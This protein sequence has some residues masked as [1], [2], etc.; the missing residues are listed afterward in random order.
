MK[1]KKNAVSILSMKR[2]LLLIFISS[3]LLLT[4]GCSLSCISGHQWQDATCTSPKKCLKCGKTDGAALSHI[5]SE[6]TCT[7]P[8]KC[9]LCGKEQ[10]K[11]LG[12]EI[13]NAEILKS[14]TCAENGEMKGRCKICGETV[15]QDIEPTGDHSVVWENEVFPCK[16]GTR[17]GKCSVCG[18]E[19]NEEVKKTEDHQGEWYITDYNISFNANSGENINVQQEL[20]CKVCGEK[21]QDEVSMSKEEYLN[22]TSGLI[23]LNNKRFHGE[24]YV[25]YQLKNTLIKE[26]RE[27]SYVNVKATLVDKNGNAIAS[28]EDSIYHFPKGEIH[29]GTICIKYSGEINDIKLEVSKVLMMN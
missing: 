26:V 29:E 25:D 24:Y 28:N 19:I 20:T 9:S 6:A 21:I 3:M 15:T 1:S 7:L 8:Q 14:P 13:E 2:I 5:F 17:I 27:I 10:G 16:S 11:P 12:H 22:K 18:K 23:V 4:S